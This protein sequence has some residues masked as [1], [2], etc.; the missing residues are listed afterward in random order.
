MGAEWIT[1]GF[2]TFERS[3]VVVVGGGSLTHYFVLLMMSGSSSSRQMDSKQ[4]VLIRVQ[5]VYF[6]RARQSREGRRMEFCSRTKTSSCD[7]S[8][9]ILFVLYL[10]DFLTRLGFQ[11]Q[12]ACLSRIYISLQII[13]VRK[14]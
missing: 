12:D 6:M 10:R 13:A 2:F 4:F 3:F 5:I 8:I 1:E 7:S 11:D 9:G 14:S